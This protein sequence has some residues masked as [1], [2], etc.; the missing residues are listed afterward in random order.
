MDLGDE[1]LG[2]CVTMAAPAPP[3]STPS[4]GPSGRSPP[5]AGSSGRSPPV[6]AG[7]GGRGFGGGADFD[8]LLSGSAALLGNAGLAPRAPGPSGGGA[9]GSGG[10]WGAAPVGNGGGAAPPLGAFRG[11]SLSG[12]S[13]G[14]GAAGFGSIGV[15][16]SSRPSKSPTEAD[17]N[18]ALA[19]LSAEA[20]KADAWLRG[21][22]K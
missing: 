18:A 2:Q 6:S 14:S 19:E 11:A 1:I 17:E 16:R 15:Q 3:T 20:L 13:F 12:S 4:A 5:L 9:A 7:A 8:F 21:L 22:D 10:G